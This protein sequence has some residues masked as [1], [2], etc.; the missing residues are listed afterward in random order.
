MTKTQQ[1]ERETVLHPVG[2]DFLVQCVGYRGLAHRNST[3][4]WKSSFGN[5]TL[6][7][8]ISFIPTVDPP[9]PGFAIETA[10]RN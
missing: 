9:P 5:K 1:N 6:P 3:G 2:K 8:N 7:K 10:G 4:Q